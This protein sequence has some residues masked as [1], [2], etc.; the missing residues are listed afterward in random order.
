[1]E[2]LVFTKKQLKRETKKDGRKVGWALVLY[3]LLAN[4]VT[5]PIAVVGVLIQMDMDM[6][7]GIAQFVGSLAGLGFIFLFFIGKGRG[8]EV[9]KRDKKLSFSGF[10]GLLCVFFGASLI[11]DL[12]VTLSEVGLNQIGYTVY[13]ED[14]L[15]MLNSKNVFMLLSIW[16]LAPVGEELILRGFLMR[17]LEKHGRL[18]AITVTSILFGL[19]HG[20]F[21]QMLPATLVG[22]VLGYA[23]MEYSVLWSIVLH[24][25]N[26]M[27]LC[28]IVPMI[29]DRFGVPAQIIYGYVFPGICLVIGTVVVICRRKQ[30][31]AWVRENK[32]QK[33]K[34]RWSLMTL[35]TVIFT[36]YALVSA[37]LAIQPM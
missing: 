30:L 22:F 37:L 3:V 36:I 17:R 32:W 10:L 26:N 5:I 34:L 27:V 29:F 11:S 7:M 14:L 1:M 15:A 19:M 8:K 9:F 35:G 24:A 31:A 4:V 6:L 25:I 33:G 23:A 21:M 12:T 20:N 16:V 28:G 18:L 13:S 2:E